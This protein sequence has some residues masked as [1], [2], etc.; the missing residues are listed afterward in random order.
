MGLKAVACFALNSG[1]L[2]VLHA[3][4]CRTQ[5]IKR[6]N[7]VSQSQL[8]Q[9]FLQKD[10]YDKIQ[11]KN[12]EKHLEKGVKKTLIIVSHGRSGSSIVGDIF[13]HHPSVFYMYEPLQTVVRAFKKRYQL[14]AKLLGSCKGIPR[15]SITLYNS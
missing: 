1:S 10:Y 8:A 3:S 5:T 6:V 9:E 13:N 12:V 2:V 4:C 7:V 15:R 11:E 14:C